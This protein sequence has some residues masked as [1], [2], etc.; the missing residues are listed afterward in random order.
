MFNFRREKNKDVR[1]VNF[2]A[3]DTREWLGGTKTL[4]E[5]SKSL[6]V[7]AC[8]S[9]RAD[10]FASIGLRLYRIKN[11]KGDVEEIF[12]HELVEL[13]DK[14][15][16]F[17]TRTQALRITQINKALTGE[18][19][20]L[21]VRDEKGGVKELWNLRP[22]LMTIHKDPVEYIRAYEYSK[23]DGKSV[24]FD[25]KDIIPIID[26]DP[27]DGYRGISPLKPA[28]IIIE[29]EQYAQTFQRDFFKNSA[30][31]DFL[32]Q[33]DTEM[34]K[35][36]VDSLWASWDDRHKG[37]GKNSRP[38]VLHSGLKFQ[39]ISLTQDQMKYFETLNFT[40]DS[41]ARAF[42]VPKPLLTSDDV[43][44][45]N[46]DGAMYQFLSG[47]IKNEMKALAEALN[48]FLAPE[49]GEEFYCDFADPTPEDKEFKLKE[50][51]VYIEKGVLSI[52]EVRDE[53]N[54]QPV[55]GGD[56]PMVSFGLVPLGGEKMV[57]RSSG[58]PLRGR[59]KLYRQL[60]LKE[61]VTKKI[62]KELARKRSLRITPS[63][64]VKE[65]EPEKKSMLV[66]DLLR[67]QYV[68]MS[69]RLIDARALRLKEALQKE[70]KRQQKRVL[71]ALKENEKKGLIEKLAPADVSRIFDKKGEM[72]LFTTLA[73]PFMTE[74]LLE[75]GQE[76]LDT[77]GIP[78]DFALT[79]KTQEFLE[80]RAAFFAESV[81]NT[82]LEKLSSALAEGIDA[83]EGIRDLSDRVRGVYGE[84]SEYR[85]EL[86]ARTEA[87]AVT[88][89][90][91]IE[92]YQQ[93]GVVQGKEWVS[94]LDGRTRDEH[95]AMNGETTS[96][97]GV[98]SNGLTAPEEPNCRCRV[99]AVI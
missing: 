28:K 19:Y 36:G 64:P 23:E 2:S 22:D 48:E 49:Y 42:G 7:F 13:I 41:I 50:H 89:E 92:G 4:T 73:L 8:V 66:G 65:A 12:D 72:A 52:N 53:I 59:S 16:P 25:P 14:W 26:L 46:H 93:S 75:A 82:T 15:N 17:Q 37:A 1:L 96:L 81:N 68:K 97:D 60:L 88:N 67:E 57:I 63:T 98:F 85:A 43:N 20:I 58:N 87:T 24:I 39:Q 90:G 74:Y 83:G 61:L 29:T 27:M 6:D 32:L 44:R 3:S 84:F 69:N 9:M 11:T 95:L 34:D 62:K 51:Q 21:K 40:R 47:K 86:I 33:T 78:R 31:P 80:K 45:A 35:E 30:R 77:V 70:V 71:D 99:V 18:A 38:A 56:L 10:Q 54:R 91:I 76:G 55:V 79:S 5:Y 94:T